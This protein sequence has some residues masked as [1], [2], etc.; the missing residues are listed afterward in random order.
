MVIGCTWVTLPAF[1][2]GGAPPAAPLRYVAIGC[3]SRAAGTSASSTAARRF[4]LTDRRGDRPTAYRLEG[5]DA[6]TLEFHVG[7]TVEVA[8]GLTVSAGTGALTLKVGS[9]TYVSNSCR[10][11]PA[12]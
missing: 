2:Q 9:L 5:G 4:L 12:K 10:N 3:I 7:H 6:A 8:G 11:P 1:A